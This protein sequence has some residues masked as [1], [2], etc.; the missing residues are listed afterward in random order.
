MKIVNN[1]MLAVIW[2]CRSID[3]W[4]KVGTGFGNDEPDCK[5]QFRKKLCTEAKM[6][7]F[8][9]PGSF[10]GGFAVALQHK[11]LALALE[12][13]KKKCHCQ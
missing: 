6:E 4:G 9:M 1:P 8:I 2:L 5:H 13:A 7:K 10:E 11:D 12:T 3:A